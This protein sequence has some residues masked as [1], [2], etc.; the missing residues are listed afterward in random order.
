MPSEITVEKNVQVAM[1]DGV[2]LATD[3]YRPQGDGRC[4][5]SS[6][7]RRTTRRARRCA[8]TRSTSCAPCRP[9]TSCVVQDTRG[10]YSPT[11]DVQPVLRRGADGADTIA[12]VAAQPW[13]S[14]N[15]GMVG[16][17]YFGATQWLPRARR[18]PALKAIA[19]FIT[20]ADYHEGW[21][22]QGGAFE[23]GFNLNWTLAFLALGEVVRRLGAGQDA[24]AELR[25]A[26]SRRSTTTTRCSS[27]CRSP[28]C[29]RC[30]LAPVLLDWLAHPDY[31]EYWRAI[32]PKERYDADHRAG[33]QHR[34]LVRP[35]PR[36]HA[37][38]LPRHEAARRD[39]RRPPAAADHR[40]VGA[41][42]QRR[43]VP[44]ARTA[45]RPTASRST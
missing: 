13:C 22:Y 28:T 25:S 24:T 7:A 16:G 9:A 44:A 20:A 17:S 30:E 5:R 34:R 32:A 15:V 41:R 26:S 27:A 2:E 45:S 29:R 11:G 31:D 12:W 14:G 21:T 3:V 23:L 4:P 36:R 8:T 37:G 1:R 35:V 33:A 40:P 19:P 42:R 39:R 43:L 6:S 18:P 38:Q 10:R